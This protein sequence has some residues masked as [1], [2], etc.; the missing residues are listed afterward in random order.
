[1]VQKPKP[2][3]RK[4]KRRRGR[5]AQKHK[6][7][8]E[9]YDQEDELPY[10]SLDLVKHISENLI[11][12]EFDG[13]Q[14]L[15][16]IDIMIQKG[17]EKSD[18]SDDVKTDM[19][20]SNIS[21]DSG[22]SFNDRKPKDRELPSP[23]NLNLNQHS[24]RFSQ[25]TGITRGIKRDWDTSIESDCSEADAE[26]VRMQKTQRRPK[27]R[28]LD[29]NP[30][31]WSVDDVFRYL[32]KTNDCK[33]IAYR[34]KE[35]VSIYSVQRKNDLGLALFAQVCAGLHSLVQRYIAY[36]AQTEIILSLNRVTYILILKIKIL[37]M[38]IKSNISY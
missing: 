9:E 17:L 28:K 11:E 4:R 19:V 7:V 25:G 27:T 18:K 5:W 20:S 3:G 38:I 8:Q 1:M 32:R 30:L 36:Y 6:E 24:T 10:I 23:P 16:E 33:D 37:F 22:S 26:Y 34:I 29:S 15:S 14:P 13:R 21:E 31:Y 35:E 12:E 2:W